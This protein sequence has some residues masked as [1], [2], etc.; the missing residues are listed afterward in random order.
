MESFYS[1]INNYYQE[2]KLKLDENKLNQFYMEVNK[3]TLASHLMW[4]VWSLVQAQSSQ[5]EFN[6]VN[7]AQIR[8]DRYFL[9]KDELINLS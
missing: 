1:K 3:F 8:F 5:L 2:T 4:G 9:T 7:Y 6:F